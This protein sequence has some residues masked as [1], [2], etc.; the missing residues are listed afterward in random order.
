VTTDGFLLID[1]PG[2]WT[3]H[4]VVAKMRGLARTRKI[5]HAGTLDPMATGL[6]VLGLGRATRLLRFV[7]QLPKEYVARALL[8]VA[9]DTLD[10]D[11]TEV[12]RT[13]LAISRAELSDA[14]KAFV[15]DIEQI[16][17]MVSAVKIDGQKLYELARRGEE[18]ERPARSVQ[19]H[20]L[21]LTAFEPGDFPVAEFR[22]VCSSGTYV[23]TLADDIG[24]AL[25]GRAHL[26]GL[27]RTRIGSHQVRDAVPLDA[28][29]ENPD[30]LPSRMLSLSDG[31]A[32]V[33]HHT[34]GDE[35]AGRISHGAVLSLDE[36]PVDGPT[37]V[38][39]GAGDLLAVYAR[40]GSGAKP[41]VV[42]A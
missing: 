30:Q 35:L 10:A 28:L 2:G 41:E 38:V 29:I 18:V 34:V 40:H 23:R 9:T 39:N 36:L 22:V 14:M 7:Q 1:K 25:G 8:G 27:Q 16:P 11:G 19:I 4:D 20:E 24:R 15:G 26:T 37:A 42:V 17:P 13:P 32:D 21:E 31:L 12:A 3:S 6:L 33:V 5:G